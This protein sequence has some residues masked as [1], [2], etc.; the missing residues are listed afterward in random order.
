[1]ADVAQVKKF[2]DV[3]AEQKWEAPA[4]RDED[5]EAAILAAMATVKQRDAALEAQLPATAG[6]EAYD[7]SSEDEVHI[8]LALAMTPERHSAAS[9]Q[10]HLSPSIFEGMNPD[11]WWQP[12]QGSCRAGLLQVPCLTPHPSPAGSRRRGPQLHPTRNHY[13]PQAAQ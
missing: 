11:A 7:S 9:G 10:R 6:R 13:A 4:A 5:D 8:S 12:A 2:S 3:A 1:M